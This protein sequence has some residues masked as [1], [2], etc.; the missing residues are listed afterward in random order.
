MA[1]RSF[2][3]ASFLALN[4]S[5]SPRPAF[6]R[7]SSSSS[8]LS[9]Q[10][11]DSLGGL[12]REERERCTTPVNTS[13]APPPLETPGRKRS[14]PIA[15]EMP[16][17]GPTAYT[18]LSARGDLPGYVALHPAVPWFAAWRGTLG[19]S[20]TSRGSGVRAD[21]LLARRHDGIY[22][23]SQRVSL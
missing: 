1:G 7:T 18:P 8:T 9:T 13:S 23:A 15:I 2:K 19:L 11:E 17:R 6:T 5:R 12:L 3:P 4:S 21:D 16:A 10:S 22:S 20:S 14:Q